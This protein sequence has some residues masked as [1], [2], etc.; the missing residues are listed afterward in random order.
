MSLADPIRGK[1]GAEWFATAT[2]AT[3]AT[4]EAADGRTVASVATVAVATANKPI[5]TPTV[6]EAASTRGRFADGLSLV[7]TCSPL[8]TRANVPPISTSPSR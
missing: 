1:H 7:M 3:F 5:S 2:S 4:E 6:A 8:T